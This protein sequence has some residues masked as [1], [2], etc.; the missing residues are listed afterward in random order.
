MIITENGLAEIKSW[1]ETHWVHG[2]P[3]DENALAYAENADFNHDEG[4]AIIELGRFDA[5]CGHAET[6]WLFAENGDIE[7]ED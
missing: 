6:L 2:E 3:T 1:L 5:K 7:L 4:T